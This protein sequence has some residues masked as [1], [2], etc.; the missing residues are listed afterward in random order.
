MTAQTTESLRWTSTPVH[1][2]KVRTCPT[3]ISSE[4]IRIPFVIDRSTFGFAAII[5]I[6]ASFLSGL[7]VRRQLDRLDLIGVLKSRE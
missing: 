2:T 1:S 7:V 6:I 3:P 4:L 5:I